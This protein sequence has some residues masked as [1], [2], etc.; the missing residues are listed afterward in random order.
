[1]SRETKFGLL[2]VCIL[3][4]VFGVLVYK[5][6]HKPTDL[7]A[8]TDHDPAAVAVSDQYPVDK[9]ADSESPPLE[10]PTKPAAAPLLAADLTTAPARPLPAK[11]PPTKAPV[12]ADPF[13]TAPVTAKV[14]P[15][16]PQTT[17]KLPIDLDDEA[18]FSPP[19]AAKSMPVA[20]KPLPA[21]SEPDPFATD[22]AAEPVRTSPVE[23]SAAAPA[24]QPVDAFDPF[25]SEPVTAAPAAMAVAKPQAI[26]ADPFAQEPPQTEPVTTS[27][28]TPALTA[29]PVTAEPL[30]EVRTFDPEPVPVAKPVPVIAQPVA[31]SF[32]DPFAAP[33]QK[34][35]STAPAS[36]PVITVP[37]TPSMQSPPALTLEVPETKTAAVGRETALDPLDDF[38]PAKAI[39]P[40]DKVMPPARQPQALPIDLDFGTP[41]ATPAR[42]VPKTL[43]EPATGGYVVE[44]GDN[45]W[46]ISKKLYGTG[47]YFQALAS[48][49]AAVV[50]DPAK[51]RPGLRIAAPSAA[52]LDARYAAVISPTAASDASPMMTSSSVSRRPVAASGFFLHDN[53]QPMYR[54]GLED[55]LSG[56]AFNHLGRASRWV[57]ILEMNRQILKDGNTLKVGAELRLPADASQVQMT[58]A[59]GG[60]R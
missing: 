26:D 53:G 31:D 39:I 25:G 45:F 58:G 37:A 5:R 41:T 20:A 50:A 22:T 23:T 3:T 59:A 27:S 9:Q 54:V 1:M 32:D 43:A 18:F 29:A 2:L 14:L 15:T 28:R 49:N 38:A 52:E 7:V 33:P 46:I 24:T 36:A 6:M 21:Q 30:T 17:T 47:R 55:T 11:T 13:D 40:L 48:H 44:P 56:I 57:Q 12:V 60:R 16:K 19:A 51:M 42:P 35:A 34:T 8:G 4:S 10:P